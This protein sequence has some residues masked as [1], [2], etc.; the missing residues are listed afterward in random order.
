MATPSGE[1]REMPSAA[2]VAPPA[3]SGRRSALEAPFLWLTCRRVLREG[4]STVWELMRW[5][6]PSLLFPYDAPPYSGVLCIAKVQS[7]WRGGVTAYE[8]DASIYR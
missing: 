7:C 6:S 2:S 4:K 8:C 5:D 3:I 1:R